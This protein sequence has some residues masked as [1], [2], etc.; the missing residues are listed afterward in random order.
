MWIAIVIVV[1]AA[2]VIGGVWYLLGT[3]QRN[4]GGG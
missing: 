4:A 3:G 1:I 2:A